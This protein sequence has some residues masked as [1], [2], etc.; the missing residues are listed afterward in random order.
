MTVLAMS[1]ALT[2]GL[3]RSVPFEIVDDQQIQEPIIVHVH[4]NGADRPER[5]IFWIG[6]IEPGLGRYVG[7]CAV[8]VVVIE[9]VFVHARDKDIFVPVI[10]VVANGN[11]H[12]IATAGEARLFRNVGEM[13][14]AVIFEKTVRVF[15]G[16]LPERVD[17]G[18]V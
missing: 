13:S 7:E 8:S 18:S 1:V 10:I 3:M 15:R 5:P 11:A 16:G 2:V 17:I 6:L 14:F 4:P 9:R 12:V